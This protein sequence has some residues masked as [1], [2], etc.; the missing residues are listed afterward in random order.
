VVVHDNEPNTRSKK[1]VWT[2]LTVLF[3]AALVFFLGFVHL[4]SD[5]IAPWVGLMPKD[6]HKAALVIMKQAP[7]IVRPL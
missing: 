3:V 4:L 5:K 7:V 6:P 1:I 2:A